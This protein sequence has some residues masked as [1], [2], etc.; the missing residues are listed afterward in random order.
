MPT[1]DCKARLKPCFGC[2][3]RTSA[4]LRLP[5]DRPSLPR[6]SAS[7]Q[8]PTPR[9]C[10]SFLRTP[11]AMRPRLLTSARSDRWIRCG[12]SCLRP[13][14]V[15]GLR[16]IDHMRK[17]RR[18]RYFSSP[19]SHS[20]AVVS[21]AETGPW[22]QG[23]WLRSRVC[24]P[25]RHCSVGWGSGVGRG[26]GTPAPI[27]G[28]PPPSSWGSAYRV[29]VSVAVILDAYHGRKLIDGVF[30]MKLTQRSG[31]ALIT[32]AM[33]MTKGPRVEIQ[34]IANHDVA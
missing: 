25:Q 33:N 13:H 14:V 18:I 32:A 29:A 30:E 34:N 23:L 8:R 4:G 11:M 2:G 19:R 28:S 31:G 17:S 21:V 5:L 20:V 16:P 12:A 3:A 26:T 10:A 22:L 6:C 7:N 15:M 24:T 9:C 1:V 27:L